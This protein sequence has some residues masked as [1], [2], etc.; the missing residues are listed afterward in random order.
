MKLS[1][2]KVTLLHVGC[3]NATM[4]H[5]LKLV[6]IR[7]Y[8]K[9]RCLKNVNMSMLPVHYA[10]ESNARMNSDIFGH[11]F[12]QQFIP[13]VTQHLQA[14]GLP[15]KAVLLLDIYAACP[16]EDLLCSH[17]G[18][19]KA[20][21]LP[22]NTTAIIQPLDGGTCTCILETSKCNYHKFL[23]QHI[24]TESEGESSPSLLEMI[25]GI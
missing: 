7:I 1:E 5:K 21:F 14:K 12:Q 8:R 25:K 17:D 11:W 20:V 22:L 19:I 10:A 4:Q 6:L 24:L 9:P 13:A 16:D 15:C 2:D 3:V 23:L 18:Q